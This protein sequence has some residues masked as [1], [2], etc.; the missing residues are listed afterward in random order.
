[1]PQQLFASTPIS[2]LFSS[3]SHELLNE[4]DGC[5][6]DIILSKSPAEWIKYL[7]EKYSVRVPELNRQNERVETADA[8]VA[9]HPGQN[10]NYGS[11]KG[12]PGTIS[13]LR[14]PHSG[15]V[16]FF[17]YQPR[18]ADFG[19]SVVAETSNGEVR[20]SLV[21]ASHTTSTPTKTFE[22]N[23]SKIEKNLANLRRDVAAFNGQLEALIRSKVKERRH[24][25]ETSKV[26]TVLL[27]IKS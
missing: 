21:G 17:Y 25:A 4:V 23:V 8:R 5:S 27:N 12:L 26:T 6:V 11:P 10:P 13:T 18:F 24:Y 7:I 19:A 16:T 1:M 22:M 20:L 2:V 14:I 15:P 3:I 9:E